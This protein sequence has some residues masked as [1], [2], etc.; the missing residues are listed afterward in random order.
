MNSIAMGAH[1]LLNQMILKANSRPD[2]QK[3]D[4]KVGGH[5][6]ASTS[7]LHILGALHLVVRRGFDFIVNKPHAS[8]TDHSYHYL[9]NLLLNKENNQP[10][11]EKEAEQSMGCLRDFATKDQPYVFQS[12]HSHYDPDHHNFLPS[13][14]VGIPPVVLGYLA[15]AYNYLRDQG[16]KTP[17]AHFWALIGDSEFREGSLFEA[18]PD[19]AERELG[20]LTWIID[21][22]RQS[23]DGHRVPFSPMGTD[24]KRIEQTFLA[25]GWDVLQ[26]RH[27][28][29]R[30]QLF[31]KQE[32]FLFK[33][34]LEKL[35]DWDLQML[36]QFESSQI[37]EFI[38]T[39]SSSSALG[40]AVST[41]VSP[42]RSREGGNP[43]L[44]KFIK[45]LSDSELKEAVHDLGG[46]DIKIMAEAL[47]ESKRNDKKPCAVIAHTI[48]GWGLKMAVQGGNHSTLPSAQE[49]SELKKKIN[50]S[51][52][53]KD[54]PKFDKK[55]SE[56]KFLQARHEDLFEEMKNQKEICNQNK[57]KFEDIAT[58]LPQEL[59][60]P[61]KMMSYPHTQWMFGQWM[62]KLSR[63]AESSTL[64]EQ[65][66]PFQKVSKMLVSLSPDVATSTNLSFSMDQKVY[67]TSHLTSEDSKWIV[68]DKK[69]PDVQPD[70][71]PDHRFLRFEIA[72]ASAIS[73]L[74]AFG[75]IKD[76]LGVPLVPFMT[77]YDFFIKRALDQY[78]YALYWKSNFI[79]AGTPSG[80]TLSPEG[81]QHG[82]KS[83]FQ[84]PGQVTFEPYFCIE[85]DWILTEALYRH[86]TGENQDRTGVLL[87]AVTRG[88]DQKQF[89]HYLSQQARFKKSLGGQKL[90][91]KGFSV[92]SAVDESQVQSISE[93]EMMSVIR[94]DVLKGAYRLIDFKN[95]ADYRV[96][97][98][99]VNIFAM[100]ALGREASEASM[101]LLKKGIYA[102]VIIV[103]SPDLLLGG[104]AHGNEYVHL[105]ENLSSAPIVSVHDGEPGL[106]D[107]IGSILGLPQESLAVRKHSVC[108]TPSDIYE[109]HGLDPSSIIQA[110]LKV[111]D[112]AS[113][114]SSFRT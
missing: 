14:T 104:L 75:K 113:S 32:G 1:Y 26:V 102:N 62:S 46:H 112:R 77:V 51:K 21:Y 99:V 45:N 80:V 38:L 30:L 7:A 74:S 24:D 108:G 98:N 87:R 31:K 52:S 114:L 3:G 106:L 57:K 37:R 92:S 95:Y 18:I 47:E 39:K 15:L 35:S 42:S 78:F 67:Q 20:S 93:T 41:G 90:H 58:N 53:E 89:V 4:P 76:I 109:Y 70:T 36:L 54:F 55:S 69:T 40:S 71:K 34:F 72:E 94:E 13:G 111:L 23:L 73:C 63:I 33:E 79:L 85:V 2:K 60:I 103:T 83:D 9:L 6:S 65:E 81:A 8:P 22:N 82:W 12:Y 10:L 59:G 27:G 16:Y 86:M 29:K 48:K 43:A 66:K 50:F 107:N 96:D 91:P 5:S 28:E 56:G 17:S 97:E 64:K 11:S 19:F 110:S 44:K 84:I 25:N 101:E 105:K 100:G 61:L 88:V 49:L 68:E